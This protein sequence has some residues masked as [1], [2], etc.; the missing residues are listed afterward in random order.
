VGFWWLNGRKEKL[1]RP[2]QRGNY[3]LVDLTNLYKKYKL[4]RTNTAA[5]SSPEVA[6]FFFVHN[7]SLPLFAPVFINI[8]FSSTCARV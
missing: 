6:V 5:I 4:K 2:G 1:V 3:T 8:F 7:F